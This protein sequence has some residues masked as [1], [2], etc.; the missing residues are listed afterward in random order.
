MI[1]G[2]SIDIK[3]QIAFLLAVEGF[4]YKS[5]HVVPDDCREELIANIEMLYHDL[6]KRKLWIKKGLDIE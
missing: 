2:V 4:I 6:E 3:S 1:D 5:K